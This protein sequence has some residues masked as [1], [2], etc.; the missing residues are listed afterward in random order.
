MVKMIGLQSWYGLSE[1]ELERQAN[2][3]ISFNWFL[4]YQAVIPDATTARNI[5]AA[6]ANKEAMTR[7][8]VVLEIIPEKHTLVLT[9]KCRSPSA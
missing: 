8:S 9:S 2:N 5:G 7:G 6:T 4:G 1:L 3:S